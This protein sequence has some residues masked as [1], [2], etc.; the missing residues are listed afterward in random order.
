VAN[1]VSVICSTSSF[2]SEFRAAA[3][4]VVELQPLPLTISDEDTLVANGYVMHMFSAG[5]RS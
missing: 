5:T 4:E 3:S 2:Q 1:C